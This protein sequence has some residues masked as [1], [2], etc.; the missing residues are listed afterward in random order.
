V[1]LKKFSVATSLTTGKI[2]VAISLTIGKCSV[3][4]PLANEKNLS[5]NTACN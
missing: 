3:T 4:T 2:L 1:Q 5:Y